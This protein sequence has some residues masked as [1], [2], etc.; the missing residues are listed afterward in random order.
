MRAPLRVRPAF[1]RSGEGRLGQQEIV[2]ATEVL[3]R[4][5]AG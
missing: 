4:K 3:T 5:P 1:D 2:H